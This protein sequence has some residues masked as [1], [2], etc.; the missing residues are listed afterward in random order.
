[1]RAT[2]RSGG[3]SKQDHTAVV[4]ASLRVE[5]NS[6]AQQPG[7]LT[8]LIHHPAERMMRPVLHF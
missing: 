7:G 2:Y 6:P 5:Q 4:A 3:H 1:M 8:K